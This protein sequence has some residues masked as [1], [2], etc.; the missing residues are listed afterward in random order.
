MLMMEKMKTYLA[1]WLF[2]S[3]SV[4]NES[5]WADEENFHAGVVKG[6]VVHEEINVSHAE[7]NK[8]NLLSF[9]WKTYKKTKD[10]R[11]HIKSS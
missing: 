2:E 10:I 6:Y 7:N 5:T 8:E 11:S 4:D 9:A 1:I 3:H